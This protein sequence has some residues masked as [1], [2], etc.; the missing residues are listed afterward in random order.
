ML[1]VLTFNCDKGN[2][3]VDRIG[4][5]L[6]KSNADVICLQEFSPKV[7]T[8][9]A[10]Y[11]LEKEYV[12]LT[13]PFSQGWSENVIYTRLPVIK[14]NFLPVEGKSRVNISATVLLDNTP[15][16][17]VCIHLDP[18]RNYTSLRYKQY[19]SLMNNFITTHGATIITGDFNMAANEVSPWPPATLVGWESHELIPTYSSANK[20]VT[21]PKGAQLPPV[22]GPSAF[23]HPFDRY[24]Y[25]NIT[26]TKITLIGVGSPASDHYGLLALFQLKKDQPIVPKQIISKVPSQTPPLPSQILQRIQPPQAIQPKNPE[27]IILK[28]RQ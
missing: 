3:N 10:P 14:T 19:M 9:L 20:C 26:L 24:L 5:L 18:G 1:S 21:S 4:P 8:S 11:N 6:Q 22:K 23:G 16:E 17:V 15:I 2:C 25:K 7:A 13:S 27:K 12:F 28:Q